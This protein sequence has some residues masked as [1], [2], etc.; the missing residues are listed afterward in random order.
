MSIIDLNLSGGQHGRIDDIRTAYVK[1]LSPFTDRLGSQPDGLTSMPLMKGTQF[2][3]NTFNGRPFRILFVGRAV[4]GWEIP[5]NDGTIEEK[6][7][8]VFDSAIDMA[9]V[10]HG[11]IIDITGKEI[12]NYNKSP[13]FQL[14]HAVLNQYGINDNW[15]SH[16]AWTN[17]YKVAPFK[18]GNPGNKIIKCTL[19]DCARI[20]RKEIS[21]LRPTHIV[22]ITDGWWYKPV[23]KGLNEMAFINETGVDL[24][25]DIT[26]L[27]IGG[28]ISNA[29][30]FHPKMIITKR[31]ESAR[32]SRIAHAKAIYDAFQNMK[33]N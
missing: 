26:H 28:G 13:F 1:M 14:C 5:F 21:Y 30:H 6:V 10:A 18:T 11:K 31:P 22:F 15:S 24:Y 4:N 16:M 7:A 33:E 20:L 9:S 8:Q 29:F 12:Y 19:D 23:G 32:I 2:T 27:I 25:E 3:G 17:L